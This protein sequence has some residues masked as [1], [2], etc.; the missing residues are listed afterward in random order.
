MQGR[1][2]LSVNTCFSHRRS[3]FATEKMI[4]RE[5]RKVDMDYP[6]YTK[7]QKR[8]LVQHRLHYLSHTT[9]SAVHKTP[10][11]HPV[12]VESDE[13][14]YPG[15]GNSQPIKVEQQPVRPGI[16]L[17]FPIEVSSEH[18]PPSLIYTPRSPGQATD[19]VDEDPEE[20]FD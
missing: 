12:Q 10:H 9:K 1:R 4:T 5:I 18:V 15:Q 7:E 8:S 19:L 17:V 6:Y 13:S 3:E 20:D 16:T 2:A 11:Q 14:H